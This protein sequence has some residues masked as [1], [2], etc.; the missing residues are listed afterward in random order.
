MNFDSSDRADSHAMPAAYA[1]KQRMIVDFHFIVFHNE[2]EILANGY[3][4]TA[5]GAFFVVKPDFSLLIGS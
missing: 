4:Q 5:V 3:T 2:T 1:A